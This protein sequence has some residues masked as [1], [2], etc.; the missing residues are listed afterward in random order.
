MGLISRHSIDAVIEA[1]DIVDV[2]SS[3]VSLE[4]KSALNFFGLC[5]FH[6][7]KTP[8]FSV[9]PGKQI[10]YCFGCQKG[11]N[12]IKFIQ[13]IE[14]LPYPQAIRFLADRAGITLEESEDS[15]WKERFERQN[16][17]YEALREAA[18][19]FY[20][21]LESPAGVKARDYLAGRG[22]DRRLYRTYGLGYSPEGRS[23]LYQAL[24]DKKIS[25][26]AMLDAGLIRKSE[27]Q[28][29]YD[30]FYR[31]VMFPIMDS[32]GRVLAF[33]GRAMTDEGPKYVNSPESFIYHK[34]KHLFGILQASRSG[35][36]HWLLVEGYMDVLAL[37]R[38]GVTHAVA[39]LGTALTDAQARAIRR[40]VDTVHL[41]M[42]ND[43]AGREASLRAGTILRKTG[44]TVR[45]LLLE[46]AKDPDDFYQS[47]GR[48]RLVAALHETLDRSGFRLAI[49]NQDYRAGLI[50]TENEF[51]DQ[52]LDMLAEEPDATKREIYGGQIAKDLQISHRAV[53]EEIERRRGLQ[54]GSPEGTASSGKEEEVSSKTKRMRLSYY[55]E[56]DIMLL[57]LLAANNRAVSQEA[58][59]DR[60]KIED[61]SIK[62]EVRAFLLSDAV[63]RPL[64]S[65]DFTPGPM[66]KIAAVALEDARE[67]RLTLAGLHS[68]VDG[69]LAG[70]DQEPEGQV[71]KELVDPD[72]IHSLI[73]QLDQELTDSQLTA[74][75][76]K[77]VFEQKLIRRRLSIWRNRASRLNQEAKKLE[78]EGSDDQAQTYN[79][80]AAGLL[81]AAD[82]LIMILQGDDR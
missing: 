51:R 26:E 69:I 55:N 20:A 35:S 46:G 7:E 56:E 9:S 2:V 45:Y 12:V 21:A 39:P 6:Q 50:R 72:R 28:S 8:S 11:G 71:R 43:P 66:R 59:I 57:V 70:D 63:G 82:T 16:L 81:T 4:K 13:E 1:N 78:L 22:I 61:Y 15:Q 62:N 41:L 53:S 74:D 36:Q 58:G 14:H 67:N 5:P 29:Y 3:Y 38:A 44:L 75:E 79:T 31:R 60:K 47:Y 24:A 48:E 73:Q 30:F 64:D 65:R 25:A 52:V 18:R 54:S 68:I 10:F 33:G 37:A 32:S 80:L 19:F 23:E 42:D 49:L 34:G 77:R 76:G 27:G 40:Y 17:A